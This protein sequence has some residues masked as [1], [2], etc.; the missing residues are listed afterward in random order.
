MFDVNISDNEDIFKP[1]SEVVC[2]FLDKIGQA[3]GYI[4]PN[5][6]YKD[7]K[8]RAQSKIIDEI[9]AN[10][11][12]NP[13]ERWA[14]IAN[15]NKITKEY[16]NQTNIIKDAIPLL[17]KSAK[18]DSLDEDWLS[19]FMDKARLVSNKDMQIIWSRILAEE[20]N[21]PNSMSK[22]LMLILA[23]M[24]KSDADRFMKFI[25]F[26]FEQ[27]LDDDSIEKAVIIFNI[28]DDLCKKHDIKYSD[29]VVL[30]GYNLIKFA[31][32][33][34]FL[35]DSE[36]SE[37]KYGENKFKLKKMSEN[38]SS[39]VILLTDLGAQLTR[40]CERKHDD[41]IFEY[42]KNKYKNEYRCLVE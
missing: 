12:I 9:A 16:V 38:I 20:T 14:F 35:L 37:V 18:P 7:A 33:S 30:E 29:V 22:Q 32:V 10:E 25:P 19:M 8:A 15:I 3:S 36:K 31:G 28:Y 34:K 17:E 26:V 42:V 21:E 23:Q 1:V 2:K 39:G 11:D 41:E 5:K 4:F 27:Y 24:S 13:I 6:E 40:I